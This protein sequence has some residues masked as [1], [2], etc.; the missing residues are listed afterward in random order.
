MCILIY[1]HTYCLNFYRSRVEASHGKRRTAPLVANR[2]H[3]LLVPAAQCLAAFD[4]N[5]GDGWKLCD[6][7]ILADFFLLRLIIFVTKIENYQL[8]SVLN[9]EFEGVHHWLVQAGT[10][11]AP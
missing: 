11:K 2:W 6:A 4:C 9:G 8:I 7:F 1:T 3:Q 5:S 10:L